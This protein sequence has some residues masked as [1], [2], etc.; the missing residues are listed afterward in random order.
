MD[1]TQ[2]HTSVGPI[3]FTDKMNKEKNP[4][5]SCGF[6]I[7]SLYHIFSHSLSFY[8]FYARIFSQWPPAA[9]SISRNTTGNLY[10]SELAGPQMVYNLNVCKSRIWTWK[11][12]SNMTSTL[13]YR[14]PMTHL[15]PISIHPVSF[16]LMSYIN[17][18]ITLSFFHHRDNFTHVH[19]MVV[20]VSPIPLLAV[21]VPLAFI[22][23]CNI[24]YDYTHSLCP[25]SKSC[26]YQPG[27]GKHVQFQSWLLKCELKPVTAG[28]T[29]CLTMHRWLHWA[30]DCSGNQHVTSPKNTIR[31]SFFLNGKGKQM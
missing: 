21:S 25:Y 27:F 28:S 26:I 13:F 12:C 9:L 3:S 4:P 29:L 1:P 14:H 18:E 6:F 30:T 16:S 31:F 15:N 23:Q 5:P 19:W 10:N 2:Q 22:A 17:W 8:L 24:S 11:E 20:C 7:V